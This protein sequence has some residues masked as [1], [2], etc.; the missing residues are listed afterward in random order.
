VAGG[1]GAAGLLTFAI[2]GIAANSTYNDL[3][4]ACRGGPCPASNQSEISR[5]KTEQTIANVGLVVGGVGLAAGAT[6]FILS[7]P[8][9]SKNHGKGQAAAPG[10]SMDLVLK[11]SWAGIR[12]QF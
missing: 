3:D 7:A 1:I 5:G 2:A 4:A 6:L 11:P 10:A 9:K 12:G 8:H